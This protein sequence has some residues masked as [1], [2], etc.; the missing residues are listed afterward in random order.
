MAMALTTTLPV[1]ESVNGALYLV[2]DAEG[3]PPPIV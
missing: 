3:V 1:P 2:D